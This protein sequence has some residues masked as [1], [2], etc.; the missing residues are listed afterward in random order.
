MFLYISV[1]CRQPWDGVPELTIFK[2]F[3]P[4]KIEATTCSLFPT[5]L[6]CCSPLTAI[7]LPRQSPIRIM[8]QVRG[9]T[10]YFYRNLEILVSLVMPELAAPRCLT[11]TPRQFRGRQ[12]RRT[13]AFPTNPIAGRP[14]AENCPVFLP[15]RE[16][17]TK[18]DPS[19]RS[20]R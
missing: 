12:W 8:D 16:P 19:L 7:F 1:S 6:T 9:R 3:T 14:E 17:G 20:S 15:D 18:P 11:V 4:C 2:S 5:P 13:S 10:T